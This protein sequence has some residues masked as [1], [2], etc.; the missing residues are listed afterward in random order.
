MVVIRMMMEEQR[1]PQHNNLEKKKI[2]SREK[3]EMKA[4]RMQHR[5]HLLWMSTQIKGNQ[6]FYIQTTGKTSKASPK[7]KKETPHP[8][9]GGGLEA[10]SPEVVGV[11]CRGYCQIV[12][13]VLV[14]D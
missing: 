5:N 4:Y 1:G 3:L 12:S 9:E 6:W 2:L 8:G 13:Q 14:P 7:S 11:H 10:E